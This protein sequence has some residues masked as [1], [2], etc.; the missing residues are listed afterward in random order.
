M[1]CV[2]LSGYNLVT[3]FVAPGY[4]FLVSN[5]YAMDQSSTGLGYAAI[6]AILGE[7]EPIACDLIVDGIIS[8]S[9]E[10]LFA[11]NQPITVRVTNNG[12][13]AA[14]GSLEVTVNGNAIEAQTVE[15]ASYTSADYTFEYDMSVPGDYTIVATATIDGD[16][17]P[18]NNSSQV[19]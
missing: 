13:E 14:L 11:A 5:G 9:G 15:L 6:R 8:P 17:N 7:G 1:L 12:S 16:E 2:G 4:L 10:G 3:D 19:L 18:D